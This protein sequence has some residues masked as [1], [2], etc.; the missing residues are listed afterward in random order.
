MKKLLICL[1]AILCCASQAFADKLTASPQE[2]YN[3]NISLQELL[4]ISNIN[5]L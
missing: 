2:Y 5:T 1:S 3:A 4:I